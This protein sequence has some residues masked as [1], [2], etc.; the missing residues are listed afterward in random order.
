MYLE[1]GELPMNTSEAR[2]GKSGGE[3]SGMR[4]LMV[5][6]IENMLRVCSLQISKGRSRQ[7]QQHQ[8]SA[9][10]L[11]AKVRRIKPR[12]AQKEKNARSNGILQESGKNG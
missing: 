11:Q 12:T 9:K 3:W 4:G 1:K 10:Q 7:H 5:E 2:Q 8:E 6:A